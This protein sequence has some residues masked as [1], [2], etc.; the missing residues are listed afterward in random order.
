MTLPRLCSRLEK[1]EV[2]RRPWVV[3]DVLRRA[4]QCAPS[5]VGAFLIAE[6]TAVDPATVDAIMDQLTEA[7]GAALDALIGPELFA[8][9]ETLPANELEAI[10]RGDPVALQ[11]VSRS[12]QRWRNGRA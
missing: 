9:V 4:R 8:F 7:E 2:L 5:E 12:Y 6:L 1:L 10:S 3:A 11:R